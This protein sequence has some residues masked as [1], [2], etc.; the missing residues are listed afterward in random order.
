MS[1][2]SSHTRELQSQASMAKKTNVV[3]VTDLYAFQ[4]EVS[5]EEAATLNQV[6]ERVKEQG[7]E[8]WAAEANRGSDWYCQPDISSQSEGTLVSQLSGS[9]SG[10]AAGQLRKLIRKG[11]PPA[12][13]PKVWR[14]VSGVVKKRSTVPD[15]YYQ[16]LCEAVKGR[17]TPATRQID[18]VHISSLHSLNPSLFIS[19]H[20]SKLRFLQRLRCFPFLHHKRGHVW[21]LLMFY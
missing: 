11:I 3:K 4:L 6:T 18:H 1:S 5:R 2:G 15:T 13:R 19:Q 20:L 21:N 14:A 10:S 9:F 12:L 17:E 8:W 7:M 16:D